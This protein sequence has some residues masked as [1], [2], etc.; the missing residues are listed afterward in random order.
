M[1][2]RLQN[3]YARRDAYQ[4]LLVAAAARGPLASYST[5][6]QSGQTV[7]I[8]ETEAALQSIEKQIAQLEAIEGG[9]RTYVTFARPQ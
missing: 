2:E 5:Q 6:Q 3:L 9:A 7:N 8:A 1:S 4:A